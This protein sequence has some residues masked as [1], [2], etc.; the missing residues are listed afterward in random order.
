MSGRLS[1]VAALAL[2]HQCAPTIAPETL[3]SVAKTES[4]LNPLAIHDNTTG[5]SYAPASANEAN[6]VATSLIL[7]Q[8]HS[9]DLGLMQINSANLA[10]SNL[11]VMHAFDACRSMDAGARII[12]TAFHHAL[13][14]ALSAYNTGDQRRGIDN[15]YVARVEAVLT[16][17][18][19]TAPAMPAATPRTSPLSSGTPARA[20]WD[21]FAQSGGTPFVFTSNGATSNAR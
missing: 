5:L 21:V 20:E 8:H 15:G 14:A 16:A 18:R 3:V 1:L 12:S 6:A 4:G 2:A 7:S 10:A 9:V 19:V 11:D 17:L 13:H